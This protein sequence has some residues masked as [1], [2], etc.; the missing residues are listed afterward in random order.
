M[1]HKYEGAGFVAHDGVLLEAR[2]DWIMKAKVNQRRCS[3]FSSIAGLILVAVP[4]ASGHPTI[5]WTDLGTGKIQR[6]DD[7]SGFGQEDLV[8]DAVMAPVDVALDLAAGKM[9]WTEGFLADFMISRA[10]LDG[11]NVELLVTGLI[12]P[13]GIEL[14]VPGGK[15]YWTD[16]GS[17]KIQRANLDGSQ[18]EDLVTMGALL[19]VDIALDLPHGKMYWTEASPGEYMVLRANLDGSGQEGLLASLGTDPSG[20]AVDSSGGKVYWTDRATS[21]IQRANLDG[22]DVQDVVTTPASLIEPVRIALDLVAGQIYWT[23]ASPADFMISRANLDGS[24]GEFLITG[25]TS[26]SGIALDITA[27]PCSADFNGDGGINAADL[28]LLLGS[29]GPCGECPGDLNDDGDVDA[30]DLALLLASWGPC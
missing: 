16:I 2:K 4:P 30:A 17:A 20:I 29:W 5:Y 14:D 24:E 8:T 19:P 12:S 3:V 13:S 22:T 27:P 23:E 9:Y 15:I 26:P 18:A 28:A 7:E 25:L 1:K 21:K 11:S 10:D 6:L